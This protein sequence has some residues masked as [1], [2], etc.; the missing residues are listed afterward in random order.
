[1]TTE[2]FK[3]IIDTI[4]E[5]SN[6]AGT[7]FVWWLCVSY[8][9]PYIVGIV[10]IFTAAYTVIRIF[11]M[12]TH[13]GW[14]KTMASRYGYRTSYW[15]DSVDVPRVQSHLEQLLSKHLKEVK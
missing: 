13:E 3:L 12:F 5:L 9:L 8:I 6:D 7:L 14:Y 10:S 15:M 4:K 1:M 11:G 2:E